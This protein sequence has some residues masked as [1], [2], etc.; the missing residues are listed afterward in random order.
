MT[1]KGFMENTSKGLLG[2]KFMPM[3]GAAMKRTGFSMPPAETVLEQPASKSS[4]RF[5]VSSR[6]GTASKKN[7]TDNLQ[8]IKITKDSACK[9]TLMA[10][11]PQSY[12]DLFYILHGHFQDLEIKDS[13]ILYLKDRLI[14]AEKFIQQD[15]PSESFKVY[16]DLGNY[17]DKQEKFDAA[18]YF[19][20]RCA[21]IAGKKQ[22]H[23]D[24]AKAYQG[25]GSCAYQTKNIGK[26]IEMYEK[27]SKISEEHNL[28]TSLLAISKSLT[29][30]YR[31]EAD[32]LEDEGKIIEALEYHMKCLT[33]SIRA[34]DLISQGN[35][36][37]RV[38]MIY[39]KQ[40][41][42]FKALE[43]LKKYLELSRTADYVDGI[44]NALSKLAATYQAMGNMPQAIQHL[45]QLNHEA[46]ESGR[47]AAEAEAALNLGLVYQKQGQY[48]KAVEFL[49]KHFNLAR[50]LQDRSLIDAGRV[51]LGV[52]Q[53]NCSVNNYSNVLNG[54][55]SKLILWKN[56]R[57]K[58]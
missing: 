26:A 54:N 4:N 3:A 42:Y 19:Y 31:L 22:L 53:A 47:H 10:G 13:N 23:Q 39:F 24:E 21:G 8:I 45:E 46:S 52:A 11:F 14:T 2:R 9:E 58:F 40:E 50:K 34:E 37:Y 1:S 12:I 41:N 28:R 38:G 16:Y 17:F 36:S 30:V 29:E 55:L 35:S 48:K 56:K 27:G 25:L 44:T 32:K 57:N 18:T 51:H 15:E 5:H 7:V 43:F 6:S 49:E 33:S 20:D